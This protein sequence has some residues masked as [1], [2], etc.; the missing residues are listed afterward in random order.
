MLLK[1]Q[2]NR[3]CGYIVLFIFNHCGPKYES[4]LSKN[5][6]NEH[7]YSISISQRRQNRSICRKSV[8]E[9]VKLLMGMLVSF[10]KLD[11]KNRISNLFP[12]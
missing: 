3:R 2:H 12:M 11:G 10:A 8:D 6:Q 7:L 9:V 4:M 1:F 5:R